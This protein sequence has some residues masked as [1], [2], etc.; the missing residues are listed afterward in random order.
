M[1]SIRKFSSPR[2]SRFVL[3][4]AS[5]GAGALLLAGCGANAVSSAAQS[6]SAETAGGPSKGTIGVILPETA[7]SAR[8][9][10]FD[11]P[12]LAA[13]LKKEGYAANI[14]NAQGDVQ[15]FSSLADGMIANQVKALIIASPNAEV[16]ATVEQK[17]K[18][19]GI[20][21]IDYDRLNTGG[22]TDYYVSFDNVEVGRLQGKALSEALKDKPGAQVIQIEGAP[23][24]NNAILFHKGQMEVLEP[25]YSSGKLKLVRDQFTP[26]WD[27]QLGGTQFEQILTSNA[28]KVD[29][30][31]AANDGMAGA[32][33]T[34]LKKNGLNGLVPVTGQDATLAGLQSILRGDQTMTVFKAIKLEAE[35]AAKLAAAVASN[36]TAAADAFATQTTT[37][38][39]SG[40]QIK[41]VLLKPQVVDKTNVKDVVEQG[42]LTAEQLCSSDLTEACKTAGISK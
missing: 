31:V 20:P 2:K 27:N 35:A 33:I 22:S 18:S 24:E 1:N 30:V 40:R 11:K 5:F 17:A 16:G 15:K 37:D 42:Y 29:G 36:D 34:V 41:S 38:P 14:Q 9:E 7:T 26:G 10:A 3:T 21:T 32:V 12:M 23:D 8:W 39:K 4:L 19:A 13:A 28:G 25:L 6:S